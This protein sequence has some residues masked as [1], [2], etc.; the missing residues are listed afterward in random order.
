MRPVCSMVLLAASTPISELKLST[1]GSSRMAAAVACCSCAMRAYETD[2]AV[3]IRACNWPV[4]WIG[5]NPFG[6][7]TYSKTVSTSVASATIRVAVW[8]SSTQF[9]DRS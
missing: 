9:S 3:S 7:S 6:I 8:R 5:N 1:S 2:C 4:S